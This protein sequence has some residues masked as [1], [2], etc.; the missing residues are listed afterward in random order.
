MPRHGHSRREKVERRAEQRLLE[1]SELQ[2]THFL[3][4]L[5]VTLQRLQVCV[6][7]LHRFRDFAL[8][9]TPPRHLAFRFICKPPLLKRTRILFF[10]YL[11][12]LYSILHH[13]PVQI[14]HICCH[15]SQTLFGMGQ[16]FSQLFTGAVWFEQLISLLLKLVVQGLK[17]SL[18]EVSDTQHLFLDHLFGLH[19]KVLSEPLN[20]KFLSVP[21]PSQISAENSLIIPQKLFLRQFK[22]ADLERGLRGLLQVEISELKDPKL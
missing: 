11:L 18:H 4:I 14:P 16:P 8:A 5:S 6:V 17:L 10:I 20:L 15:L 21:E 2:P 22:L 1:G 19:S 13:P 12:H 9:G 3:K 7:E